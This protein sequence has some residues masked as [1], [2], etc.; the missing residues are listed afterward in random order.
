MLDY[1]STLQALHYDKL[2]T[3][4]IADKYNYH[5]DE[6]QFTDYVVAFSPEKLPKWL[7]NLY[8]P[9]K[10]EFSDAML[11]GY[12]C[13]VSMSPEGVKLDWS[14][15]NYVANIS[16]ILDDNALQNYIEGM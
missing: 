15:L 10:K 8:T 4:S 13:N 16:D 12:A 5:V 14:W 1:L 9:T 2:R 11:S 6:T 7:D 3:I